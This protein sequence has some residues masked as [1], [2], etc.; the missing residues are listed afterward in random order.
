MPSD[1]KTEEKV[2]SSGKK[3][4]S[5]SAIKIARNIIISLIILIVL[6]G[7]FF[8]VGPG[9]KGVIFNSFIGIKDK[10]YDEGLHFKLPFF[11]TQY[12]FE[13]RTRIF[14]DEASAASKDLQVVST[15]VALN[16][17]INKEN[18]NDLFKNIGANYEERII[19]PSIQEIVKSITAKHIAEELITKREIIKEEIKNSLK[20]RLAKSY[21]IL[22]DLSITNFDFSDEFNKAIEAKVTAEQN[23]LKEQNNLQV[24]KFQAQQKI[25]QA[26]GEA[27]AIRIVNEELL[28]S[29]Q[30]INYLT[31]QKWDGKMPLAL[32]SGNL[33]SITGTQK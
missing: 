21:V 23:A 30:Y 14:R 2:S 10:T 26:K 24:I 17:H 18:V 9:E 16:Y 15:E 4:N 28:K 20:D 11:E 32:G 3:F 7:S 12:R 31:I 29:P 19:D 13:V 8:V 27:E 25:E 6:W 1:K 5:S 33:L 22:D